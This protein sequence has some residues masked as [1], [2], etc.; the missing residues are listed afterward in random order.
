[1]NNEKTNTMNGRRIIVCTTFR[2]FNG[3]SNDRIQRLF[4]AGLKKQTYQN[5]LLVPTIFNEKNVEAVLKEENMPYKAFYGDAGKYRYSQS[6]VVQNAISLIDKP[7]SY[8]L[9]WTCGDDILESDFFEKVM[10]SMTPFSCCTALPHICY[11]SIE[12]Y[13]QKKVCGY[14]YG[15]IDLICFDGDIFLNPEVGQVLKDYPNRGQNM[16]E[17]FL[18][19]IG[20]VF[21]KAMYNIWPVKIQRID[22]D[23]KVNNETH[24]IFD[25]CSALNQETYNAFKAKYNLKGDVY[26]S[27]LS[28][29]TSR[30]YQNIWIM[31]YMKIT[32]NRIQQIFIRPWM[33][34]MIP[35]GVKD[36]L[37]R[38]FGKKINDLA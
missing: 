6:Q 28:Y 34:K 32:L 25:M 23:R 17:Y 37:K 27:V 12:D 36:F 14:I 26:R 7:G 13:E 16:I 1:M 19:G 18:S 24:E 4:L 9:I 22:N 15:G 3:N 21:G 35:R 38:K 33:F 29:K 11:R 8:I 30:Q 5:Y 31:T 2:E 10:A 20:R